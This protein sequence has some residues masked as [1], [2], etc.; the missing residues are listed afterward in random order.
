MLLKTKWDVDK[1][2][3]AQKITKTHDWRAIPATQSNRSYL[4]PICP[5]NKLCLLVTFLLFQNIQLKES[6]PWKS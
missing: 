6:P 2:S 3:T 1:I 4:N 5:I